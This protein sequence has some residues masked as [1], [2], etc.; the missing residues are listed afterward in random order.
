MKNLA[1]S[2]P[3]AKIML[4]EEGFTVL[5]TGKPHSKIQFFSIWVFFQDI[6][7]YRILT[8]HRTAGE[9]GGHFKF[10]H[11]VSTRFTNTYTL[12]GRLLQRA[13]LCT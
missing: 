8:I 11:T 2:H 13:H 12:A 10:L 6:N 3:S 9:R 5:L 7:D 1:T 4:K